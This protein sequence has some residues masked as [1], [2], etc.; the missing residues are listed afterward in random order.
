MMT[1]F[2]RRG[3]WTAGTMT[4]YDVSRSSR[5]TPP[6][7]TA[8]PLLAATAA[9][10]HPMGTA[11]P[12]VVAALRHRMRAAP[13]SGATPVPWP[14]QPTELL[15]ALPRPAPRPVRLS[16]QPT[17][18]RRF[19]P[20]VRLCAAALPATIAPSQGPQ[21]WTWS[22]KGQEEETKAPR[23]PA[24]TISTPE[25]SPAPTSDGPSCF[26]CG[27]PSHFQVA[28]PN[29]PTC[30]LYKDAGHPAILCPNRLVC[31]ELMVYMDT[32]NN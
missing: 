18:V 27:L 21:Q 8:D 30:Y 16:G 3:R 15:L 6:G 29:P 20:L 25:G 10:P 28:C 14:R 5:W 4:S 9:G 22:S 19:L 31:E 11:A 12:R 17:V 23:F 13:C 2:S 7:W 26:N 24:T 32:T 1:A